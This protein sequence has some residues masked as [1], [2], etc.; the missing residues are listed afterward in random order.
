MVPIII[1]VLAASVVLVLFSRPRSR[2]GLAPEGGS[3]LKNAAALLLTKAG[4]RNLED[5]RT[6]DNCDNRVPVP[7]GVEE[8]NYNDSFVFQGAD[9]GG[10]IFLTRLGFRNAGR[11]VEVWFWGSDGGERYANDER[12]I[13]RDSDPDPDGISAGGLTYEKLEDGV[14][15]ISFAGSINGQEGRGELIWKADAAMYF[16]PVHMDP[17]STARAMAEMPWSRDY[18]ESLRS[19]NAVRIEQGGRLRGEISFGGR[20]VKLE[21]KGIRDHSWGKRDWNFITR[22]MWTILSLEQ[23][24][25]ICG[26]EAR[27]LAISPVDYGD[28]FKRMATGWIAGSDEV[29]PVAYITDMAHIGNDGVIPGRFELKFRSPDARPV[30]ID[31]ER[32]QPEMPWIVFDGRFEVNEAWC[33]VKVNGTRAYG[34]AEFGYSADRG[35]NRPFEKGDVD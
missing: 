19:E 27:Y 33:G 8:A 29:K 16:S 20:T 21:M 13:A 24:T 3:R 34:V 23:P 4:P 35:Y 26:V 32:R 22:Y 17:R 18:F 31:V 5:W 15:K 28:N 12:F 10:N 7:E 14:W 25:E 30:T 2:Q 6:I 9:A 11:E 1:G